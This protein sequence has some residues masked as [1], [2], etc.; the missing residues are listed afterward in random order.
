[1]APIREILS[2]WPPF[3]ERGGATE[4]GGTG[5]WGNQR[6]AIAGAGGE[7]FGSMAGTV[8]GDRADSYLLTTPM[9][10][11]T[12]IGRDCAT[13]NGLVPGQG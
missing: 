5:S 9:A 7:T 8:L 4:S 10:K 13:P 1:M 11:T 2:T 3:R 6:I 12:G